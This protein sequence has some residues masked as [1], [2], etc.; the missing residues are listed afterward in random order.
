MARRKLHDWLIEQQDQG[1]PVW[2][3][4]IHWLQNVQI[5]NFSYFTLIW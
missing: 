4:V 1:G 2:D 3:M 5:A